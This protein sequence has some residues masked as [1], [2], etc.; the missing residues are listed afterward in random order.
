MHVDSGGLAK[1][2]EGAIKKRLEVFDG[3]RLK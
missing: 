3:R 1:K 2:T